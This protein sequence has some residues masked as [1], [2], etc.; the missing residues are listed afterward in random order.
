MDFSKW[1]PSDWITVVSIVSNIVVAILGTSFG[2]YLGRRKEAKIQRSS[3]I[4][5][6]YA[7]IEQYASILNRIVST[8]GERGK[9]SE[10]FNRSYVQLDKVIADESIYLSYG[11]IGVLN[12]VRIECAEGLNNG[13]F[14]GYDAKDAKRLQVKL[15]MV[16]SALKWEFDDASLSVG[17][18]DRVKRC[19]ARHSALKKL[20]NKDKC[21]GQK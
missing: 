14:A 3:A 17:I 16:L 4:K 7:A 20:K 15:E 5:R 8:L 13:V 18:I 19:F 2:A 21:N 9:Y 10:D 6:I 12:N 1:T 11:S